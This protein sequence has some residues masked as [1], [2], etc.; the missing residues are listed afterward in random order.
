MWIT[1]IIMVRIIIHPY[2]VR[3]IYLI[4]KTKIRIYKIIV[5]KSTRI[6]EIIRYSKIYWIIK[7]VIT[8]IRFSLQIIINKQVLW[9][10]TQHKIKVQIRFLL[11]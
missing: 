1:K 4:I 2:S 3:I 10:L 7:I 8:K 9:T 11:A 6:K 5:V